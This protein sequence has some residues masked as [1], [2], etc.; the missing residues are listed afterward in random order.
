MERKPTSKRERLGKYELLERLGHGGMG[1]VWKARDTQLQRYVAIKLLLTDLQTDPDFIA[2]F[3]REARLVAALR[4]PNIVQIHDFQLTDAHNENS[5]AYMVMDYIEGGTLATAIRGTVRKG[6][7]WP[8]N[9]IVDLFAAISLAL[10]Y[11]HKQGMIH[12]DIKPANILLD[13]TLSTTR[14]LGE[15]ILT[16]FG[17]ARWQGGGSTVTGFVGTPLYISPEQAQSHPVDARSDL[18]SLGIILYEVLTG[19]T[20]FRGDNPLAVMLQHVDEQPP[21]PALINPLVSPALSAVVLQSIAKNPNERYSSA[22]AMTIALARAFNLPVPAVLGRTGE[23]QDAPAYNPLQ[24]QVS[25]GSGFSALHPSVLPAPFTPMPGSQLNLPVQFNSSTGEVNRVT[26]TADEVT[27]LT[28]ASHT[29]PMPHGQT[30][31]APAGPVQRPAGNSSPMHA[32]IPLDSVTL[33]PPVTPGARKAG[34]FLSRKLLVVMSLVCAGVLLLGLGATIL[35]PRLFS[36]ATPTVTTNGG[37]A[38]T[39]RFLSS[40]STVSGTYDELQIDLSK[41]APVPAGLVYYAWLSQANSES[42]TV[43][44]W[45]LQV[46]NGS[47]HDLYVSSPPRTDLYASSSLLLITGE[48]TNSTPVVPYPSPARHYYYALLPHPAASSLTFTVRS[49]PTSNTDSASNPCR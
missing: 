46:I 42:V 20:P 31:Y 40:A 30:Q 47:I 10:D 29:S 13:P 8:A 5:Q 18:Y 12:R 45:P 11:A 39:M 3:M 35:G 25:M 17:I 6:I 37:A 22:T 1:E 16:D 33:S 49:C 4:H 21:A 23:Y 38:G 26:P 2:Y 9:E 14:S 36:S 27:R 15:P 19:V 44:H 48:D 32:Q 41:V 7:F 24:P 43:P 28:P 34:G